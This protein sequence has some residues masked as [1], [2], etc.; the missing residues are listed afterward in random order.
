MLASKVMR[1]NR[2][3]LQA[4]DR[5]AERRGEPLAGGRAVFKIKVDAK[6]KAQVTVSGERLSAR[7][8][9]CYRSVSR[10]WNIPKPGH[11]YNTAFWHVH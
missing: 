6:G 2:S 3:T 1:L 4:C 9:S 8:V 5:L 11:A 7:V 10:S